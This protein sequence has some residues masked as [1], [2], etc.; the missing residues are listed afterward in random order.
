[1]KA[2]RRMLVAVLLLLIP[3]SAGRLSEI[4]GERTLKADRLARVLGFQ[5]DAI[6]SLGSLLPEERSYLE[7]FVKG[8]NTYIRN[9]PGERP[10]EFRVLGYAPDPFTPEEIIALTHFQSYASN[11]NWKHEVLRAS[12]IQ[13]LGERRGREP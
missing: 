3:L 1:M 5:R 7:S 13:E 9:Q 10:I 8:I 6:K 4:F 2:I 12:A 11:H